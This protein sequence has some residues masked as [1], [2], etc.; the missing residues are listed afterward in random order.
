M[1]NK[2]SETDIS[3]RFQKVSAMKQTLGTGL[4]ALVLLLAISCK[5]EN[6]II[7]SSPITD[8]SSIL[9]DMTDINAPAEIASVKIGTQVWM[10]KNLNVSH[11]RNGDRIPQ[12]K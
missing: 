2:T 5:K 3:P 6:S 1:N 11:Y 4:A 10:T 12:V 9:D 7:Q 8:K